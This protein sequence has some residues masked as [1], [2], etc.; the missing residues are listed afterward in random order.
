MK[1]CRICK[2]IFEPKQH[3]L[4]KRD[5]I[6]NPCKRHYDRNWREVRKGAGLKCRGTSSDEWQKQ[7]KESYFKR[8]QVKERIRVWAENYRMKDEQKP[9]IRARRRTRSAIK[10]GSIIKKP[11]EICNEVKSEAHHIDYND[12]INVVWLCSK[13]HKREHKKKLFR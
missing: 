12:P 10:N 5:Y 13:H 1:E 9:L 7:Y 11:C 6:C 3:Q 2:V 8:P 4:I